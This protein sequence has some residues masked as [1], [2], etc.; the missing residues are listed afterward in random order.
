[1][2]QQT[3]IIGMY[4]YPILQKHLGKSDFDNLRKLNH[5]SLR[6]NAVT[7][8]VKQLPLGPQVVFNENGATY[9]FN[10]PFEPKHLYIHIIVYSYLFCH[11][12]YLIGFLT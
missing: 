12:N 2:F 8:K 10:K 9:V 4:F 3:L 6:I 1:M 5:S 11:K 7:R